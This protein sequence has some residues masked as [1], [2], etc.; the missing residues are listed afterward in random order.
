[1]PGWL[2]NLD[3]YRHESPVPSNFLFLSLSF[4]NQTFD[5]TFS[6]PSF[7]EALHDPQIVSGSGNSW[8]HSHYCVTNCPA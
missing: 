2:C 7:Q 3:D 8:E 5:L 4:G 1:L 6:F